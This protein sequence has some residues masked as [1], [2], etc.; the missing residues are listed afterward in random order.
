MGKMAQ[1]TPPFV[2][3]NPAF[4]PT[5]RG[6]VLNSLTI[7]MKCLDINSKHEEPAIPEFSKL[8]QITLVTFHYLG[9]LRYRN[10]RHRA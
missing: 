7:S 3:T 1:S 2:K 9:I 6:G 10:N 8:P 5:V 4:Q